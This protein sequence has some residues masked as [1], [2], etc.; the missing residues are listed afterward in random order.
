M[1]KYIHRQ[2]LDYDH[3]LIAYNLQLSIPSTLKQPQSYKTTVHR[4]LPLSLVHQSSILLLFF[5]PFSKE[6]LHSSIPPPLTPHPL[7]RWWLVQ[8]L[9][10]LKLVPVNQADLVLL[11]LLQGT[12]QK[13]KQQIKFTYCDQT[14][15]PLY[16]HIPSS[17]QSE[18]S[19]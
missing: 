19:A 15:F 16:S 5:F 7:Q 17:P 18:Q 2:K 8:V 12:L 11:L 6:T 14:H 3:T 9:C 4:I 1:T 10:L 13:I